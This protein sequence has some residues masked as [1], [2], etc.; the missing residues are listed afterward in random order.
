NLIVDDR[1][2]QA[3]DG[4]YRFW[5][6][7]EAPDYYPLT[8]SFWW[9]QGR[10]WG[11]KA[12]GYHAVNVLLHAANVLL[13]WMALRR[14]RIPGAWLAA[15]LFAVHPVNVA[16]VAWI[17]EQ[18]NTLSMLFFALSILWYLRFDEENEAYWYGLSLAA[19]LLA[20]LSKTAVVML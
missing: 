15:L 17:S 4:L 16:T 20:L 5:C 11:K 12:G 6:T 13:I 18:K 7:T 9:L 8:S 3:R 19:F 10:L 14:L 2:I 1:M